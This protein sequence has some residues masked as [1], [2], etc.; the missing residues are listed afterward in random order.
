MGAADRISFIPMRARLAI[1]AAALVGT[2]VVSLALAG[3]GADQARSRI[4][5]LEQRVISA[6]QAIP[7]ARLAEQ[8][9]N[10]TLVAA[11]D[12]LAKIQPELVRRAEAQ[13]A[14]QLVLAGRLR[15]INRSADLD[16]LLA[17]LL[18]GGNLSA[19]AASQADQER[20][21]RE[22]VALVEHLRDDRRQVARLV[23]ARTRDLDM[24]RAAAR[25]AAAHRA[26]VVMLRDRR[27][28]ALRQA[29]REFARLQA[30]EDR[31]DARAA[32]RDA[33]PIA[34]GASSSGTPANG[35]WPPVQGGPS[36]AV[37]N[38]IA[39]C[40]SGGN[41]RAIGGGGSFRGK[42][43]F[44]TSTWKAVGGQ[45][46]P[47]AASESEQDYR[48]ALLFERAGPGQWP[49]CAAFAK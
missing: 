26:K 19:L 40:E 44:M 24:K 20:L 47:A 46:D 23:A 25:N 43:Q 7:A 5:V 8:D 29:R 31:A 33:A 1:A 49:V 15:D 12:R 16:P 27:T 22:D 39:Q 41:P 14:G 9:A 11:R 3:P 18:S 30:R 37:L 17:V 13:R 21:A 28:R 32:R 2:A 4:R 48:A 10:R 45:G 6:T 35:T 42:Y 36:K 38:K 34:Q